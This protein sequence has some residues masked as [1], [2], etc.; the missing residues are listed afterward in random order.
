[1]WNNIITFICVLLMY[2]IIGATWTLIGTFGIKIDREG[3]KIRFTNADKYGQ[4]KGKKN[5]LLNV[6]IWPVSFNIIMK[7][8]IRNYI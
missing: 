4:D 1:M 8:V 6:V 5:L 3:R 7:M 2:I